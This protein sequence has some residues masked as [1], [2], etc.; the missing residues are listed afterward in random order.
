MTGVDAAGNVSARRR[1]V[2]S[3]RRV[4]LLK[5]LEELVLAEGFLALSVD[6]LAHRLH[7]SKATLYSVAGN[8]EQ[9]VV[10]LT[11]SSAW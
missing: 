11:R 8:R 10:S 5:D 9:L 4:Q 3:E 2:D 7:C 1:R 6:D